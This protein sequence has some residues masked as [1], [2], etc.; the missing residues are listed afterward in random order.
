M[1]ADCINNNG[2]DHQMVTTMISMA[3]VGSIDNGDGLSGD[4]DGD[5]DGRF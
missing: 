3:A 1:A 5:G 4:D 2:N